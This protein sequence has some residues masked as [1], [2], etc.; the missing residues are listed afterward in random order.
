M[1]KKRKI[2]LVIYCQL[3]MGH[4]DV[5]RLLMEE[6]EA[7]AFGVGQVST[8]RILEER[9]QESQWDDLRGTEKSRDPF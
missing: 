9:S 6:K 4:I 7:D 3:T 2:V 1:K 8:V 5:D